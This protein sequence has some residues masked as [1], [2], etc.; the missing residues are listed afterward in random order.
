M[1]KFCLFS[2]KTLLTTVSV[3][4][5]IKKENIYRE[6]VMKQLPGSSAGRSHN[7]CE[8]L[9]ARANLSHSHRDQ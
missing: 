3:L 9:S 7:H 8:N 4:M 1:L 5:C 6:A 2:R